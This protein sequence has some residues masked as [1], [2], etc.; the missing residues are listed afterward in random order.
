MG[1][2]CE[3]NNRKNIWECV[4]VLGGLYPT[5]A[6]CEAVCGVVV[7]GPLCTRIRSC[8]C[9]WNYDSLANTCDFADFTGSTMTIPSIENCMSFQTPPSQPVVGDVWVHSSQQNYPQN[10]PAFTWSAAKV[11]QVGGSAKYP[12]SVEVRDPN[13]PCITF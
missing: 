5:E 2:N 6:S 12:P 11:V 10:L 4:K 1:W 13:D 9:G 3:Y 7:V 8:P